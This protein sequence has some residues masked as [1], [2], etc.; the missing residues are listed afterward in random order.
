MA[1]K[2]PQIYGFCIKEKYFCPEA[3][4]ILCFIILPNQNCKC[5]II[6]VIY[7]TMVL[8]NRETKT[9]ACVQ[10]KMV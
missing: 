2:Y 6:L 7:I 8:N 1:E 10:V 9:C 5:K 4:F 3:M